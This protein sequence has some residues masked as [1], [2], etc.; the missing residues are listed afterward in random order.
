MSAKQR[1]DATTTIQELKELVTKFATDR[2]W[3]R[4]H[5]PKNLSMN[6][7]IEAAELMEHFV[8]DRAGD[9]DREEVADELADVF[10]NVLNFAEHENIDLAGAFLRKYDKILKKYPVEK[11]NEAH[12]N[13]DN[14]R[15][16][17]KAHRAK[18]GNT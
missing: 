9:P 1:T 10:F 4:H 3:Q 5:T 2:H 8:W 6:I 15:Q 12:D 16:I 18:K 14:Y 7:A 17:K 11:F 13:L